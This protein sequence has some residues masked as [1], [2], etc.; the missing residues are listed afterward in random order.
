[1]SSYWDS[2]QEAVRKDF[3]RIEEIEA[4]VISDVE[5]VMGD[6][7]FPDKEHAALQGIITVFRYTSRVRDNEKYP[8]AGR[9]RSNMLKRSALIDE[10]HSAFHDIAAQGKVI[11][12]NPRKSYRLNDN[13]ANILFQRGLE[14]KVKWNKEG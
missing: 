4:A 9:T 2:A 14:D 3:S 7:S 8:S 6:H 10:L 5:Y 11:V 1:M 12:V 13:P